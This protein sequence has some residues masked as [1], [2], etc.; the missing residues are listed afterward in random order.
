M[1]IGNA[2]QG[3]EMQKPKSI[4]VLHHP[5]LPQSG[6]VAAEIVQAL[7]SDWKVQAWQ[8]S[9][10]D[11][12]VVCEQLPELDLL[13]ILGG[14]GSLLRAARMAA[15]VGVP[16]LGV[17]MGRTGFLAECSPIN[18][19][20]VLAAVLEGHYWIEQRMMLQAESFRGGQLL[21][22]HKALNDVVISRGSL[23]RVVRLQA[24]IDGGYLTTYVADGLIISTA[25]GSTAYALAAG[26]PVLPPQLLNILIIP[27]A[28]HMTLER[29]IVLG[30]GAVVDIDVNTDHQ[31]I[32]T[33]DGQFEFALEDGDCVTV[34]A[35]QHVASFVR[36]QPPDYFYRTLVARL[37]PRGEVE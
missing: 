36:V 35:A 15:P 8:G 19:R 37:K 16:L 11:E 20:E 12:G 22:H 32:L 29:A 33:V 30:Q 18:W 34:R 27:I 13:V 28:P 23:A 1:N 5:K 9:T 3:P 21:G 10:W 14:D 17:N 31:A 25:T 4:G 26:G 7:Q 24:H 6:Q 2:Q